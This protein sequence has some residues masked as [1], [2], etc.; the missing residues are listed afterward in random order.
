MPARLRTPD[1]LT[2]GT[3]KIAVRISS[4]P[5]CAGLT[6]TLGEPI[7]SSSANISGQSPVTRVEDI[8]PQLVS[9]SDGV[10]DG[11]PAPDGGLSSTLIEQN[12]DDPAIFHILRPGA[13]SAEEL[14]GAGFTILPKN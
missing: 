2:G 8:D 14:L 9:S 5:V 6:L 4:H 7:T 11:Q 13:I 1:L 12:E 3:G 10:L